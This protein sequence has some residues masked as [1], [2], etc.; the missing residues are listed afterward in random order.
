MNFFS[1]FHLHLGFKTSYVDPSLFVKS[2]GTS[3]AVSLLYA[4]NIILIRDNNNA[5]QYVITQLTQEF[6]MKDLGIL[7]FF[8]WVTN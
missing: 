8:P 4:D 1:K 5:I 6:D 3:I 7:Y 2:S